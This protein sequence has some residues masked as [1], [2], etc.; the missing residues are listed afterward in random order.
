MEEATRN[1]LE[2]RGWGI[3][4]YHR[5]IKQCC[6]IEQAQ[7]RK[8]AEQKSHLLMALRAFLRLEAHRLRT[9]ISW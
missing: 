6:G 1:D 5:G 3:E 9:G 8:A 7:V 4:V 2:A